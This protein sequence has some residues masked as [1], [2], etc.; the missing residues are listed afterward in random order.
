MSDA[1]SVLG[2]SVTQLRANPLRTFLT[3]LGVVFGVGSVVAMVSI[4][5]GA[6]AEIVAMIEAMGATSVHVLARQP[7]E[8]EIGKVVNDSVGLRRADVDAALAV[9]P[10]V[11][12]AAYRKKH[13]LRSSDLPTA[14]LENPALGVSE[15]LLKLHNLKIAAGR[16]FVGDD[17]RLS[18][19]VAI[20]G[21]ALARRAFSGSPIGR[22][23]RLDFAFFEVVGV[24]ADN[25]GAPGSV[26]IDPHVYDGAVLVPYETLVDELEPPPAYGELDL[27]SLE[28]GSL[29]GTLEAKSALLGLLASL[30]GGVNDTEVIAPEE[31]LAQKKA[32]QRILNVVLVCIAAISLLV[33]GIG[34]MNIMLANIM[35]RVGEI[36]LRR[37]LGARRRDIRNQFLEEAV[38]ICCIG[39]VI[40]IAFGFALSFAV[41]FFVGLPVGFAWQAMALSFTI[42]L[43]VGAGF[44]YMPAKR[45][46]EVNPIEALRNE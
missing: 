31:I 15:S 3:M 32:T 4:G 21:P 19:R 42:S 28:V 1:S 8:T 2:R 22:V 30:H 11:K 29:E 20:L 18:R 10:G 46:A 13:D 45:A 7:N 39:G 36:G 43:A 23:I 24:L 26:P 37:A 27:V 44:G 9:V 40:G 14:L 16:A 5:E 34:V 38:F 25:R 35:E 12:A 6:Q 33:G 41:G 17:H